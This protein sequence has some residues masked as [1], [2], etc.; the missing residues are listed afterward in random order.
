MRQERGKRRGTEYGRSERNGRRTVPNPNGLQRDTE[1]DDETG[2]GSGHCR[3]G[4]ISG[5]TAD[6]MD[7]DCGFR[8]MEQVSGKNAEA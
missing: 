7:M 1:G 8:E 2:I 3:T 6:F 5:S 4:D